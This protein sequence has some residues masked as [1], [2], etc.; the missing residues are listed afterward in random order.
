MAY[1]ST[2]F[3]ALN[4]MKTNR[5]I[6]WVLLFVSSSQSP[7]TKKLHKF[8][9]T[10][11]VE[12]PQRCPAYPRLFNYDALLTFCSEFLITILSFIWRDENNTH[13]ILSNPFKPLLIFISYINRVRF[14]CDIRI[15][16]T[17]EQIFSKN[18]FLERLWFGVDDIPLYF[19]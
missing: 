19:H 4:I 7:S 3:S 15:Y 18:T 16:W 13:L 11:V 1:S 6:T 9:H 14:V 8:E 5:N 17:T 10:R 12:E 2:S